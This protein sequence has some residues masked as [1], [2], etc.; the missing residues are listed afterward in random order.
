MEDLKKRLGASF[1]DARI[2]KGLTQ[3]ELATLVDVTTETI[4]NSE[5]GESLVT[6]P[7]LLAMTSALDLDLA[8]L[9]KTPQLK[10]ST[11]KTKRHRLD[12][13]VRKLT[14]QM[15]DAELELLLGIGR[16][17]KANRGR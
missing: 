5:R 14:A 4:S 8:A 13:A 15:D 10:R 16:L 17:L 6:V 3:E 7:V 12:R 1:R 9:V 11:A 2:N